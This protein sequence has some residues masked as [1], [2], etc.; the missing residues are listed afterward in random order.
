M[1]QPVVTFSFVTKLHQPARRDFYPGPV[2]RLVICHT[3]SYHSLSYQDH[4]G[5]QQQQPQQQQ[6]QQ[7]QT[8][9]LL[10]TSPAT[11]CMVPLLVIWISGPYHSL[12]YQDFAAILHGRPVVGEQ[13]SSDLFIYL[14]L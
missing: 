5:S 6:Q 8:S 7:P 11:L 4:E 2:P 13:L 10:P 1:S 14:F 9:A 3:T 12:S